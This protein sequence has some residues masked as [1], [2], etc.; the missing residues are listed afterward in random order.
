M[1]MDKSDDNIQEWD[2]PLFETYF[3]ETSNWFA[4]ESR[5]T[6]GIKIESYANAKEITDMPATERPTKTDRFARSLKNTTARI[7]VR[8]K[9]S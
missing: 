6:R 8:T 9:L 1:I 5:K 7:A 3:T 4:D 2:K